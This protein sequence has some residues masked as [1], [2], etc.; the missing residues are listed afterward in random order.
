MEDKYFEHI[1][2]WFKMRCPC[3]AINW[4]Y[5]SEMDLEKIKC[6]K[7]QKSYWLKDAYEFFTVLGQNEEEHAYN[8]EDGLEKPE[9]IVK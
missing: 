3:G 7:C 6:W 2:T 1:T 5:D 4:A 9:L 8:E